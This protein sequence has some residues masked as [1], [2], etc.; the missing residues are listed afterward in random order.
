LNLE[1][2]RQVNKVLALAQARVI[3]T[4]MD[5][6]MAQVTGSTRV[7][8]NLVAVA[9]MM[10]ALE[11]LGLPVSFADDLPVLT[12]GFPGAVKKNK[13][14][15]EQYLEA[16]R[17]AY[18]ES[19]GFGEAPSPAA[20][21]TAEAHADPG[22]YYLEMGGTLA[23]MV[24][25]QLATRR[26]PLFY[27]GFPIT[28]AGNPFYAMAQAFANGHPYIMVDENN[29]SEK[30]A[31]EKLLGV[32][33][34]G[35]A[36]PVTFTASQGWRL[37]AEIMPQ[38]VGA[39]LE[40]VFVL[41]RRALAAPA[42]NIEESHTDFMSFRDDGAIMLSP[43]S[44]QEFVPCLYLARLLTH[45]ARLPVVASLGGITDTHKISLV[46]VP[47]DRGVQAWLDRVLEDV[48][49][50]EDKLLN[51]QGEVIIHGPSATGEVYQE[52]QS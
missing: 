7:V 49:F 31:A 38:L 16:M 42:L 30:V 52:T 44:I 51:R 35:G 36:L 18:E 28:P 48:D 10:R 12:A 2:L 27:I 33:R 13:K 11:A 9:P 39:R 34:T 15:T 19:Q 17:R 37:F 45:F 50:L 23:G 20:P 47:P 14:L 3:T 46:K 21:A 1:Q 26:N 41:A 22:D 8:S 32:A 43:K 6:I 29:P 24:M 40:C 4:D 5:G 25:S